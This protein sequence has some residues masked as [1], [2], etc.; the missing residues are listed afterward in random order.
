MWL[1]NKT[2][3]IFSCLG[4]IILLFIFF[5][6]LNIFIST[7]PS[8]L[9]LTILE[10]EVIE[11]M[12]ISII[13]S[14]WAIFIGFILGIPLAY[15]LARYSF[16]G[17]FLIEGII[18]IPIVIP[19]S[20]AGIALL[21][22][23]SSNKVGGKF[24]KIFNIN[25]IGEIPGIV[26]A[27]L[28]VSVPFLINSARDGFKSI[29]LKIENVARSLGANSW[30]VFWKISFPLAWKNILSGIML[31]WG[32]GISEFGAVIILAYHPMTSSVLI[33]ER[34]VTYGLKYSGPIS[35]ILILG[36]LLFFILSQKFA[37]GKKSD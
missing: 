2:Q 25:F 35:C 18:N 1:K 9:K 8:V 21:G 6:V 22:V 3:F 16:P 29:D 20:A 13:S 10:K 12:K 17:K 7:S 36:C 32:R 37:Y 26:I 28:F 27:M 34:F 5:P 23:F 15:Q 4:I 24:F 11:S 30:Q 19:H 33:Y 14:L 31:M